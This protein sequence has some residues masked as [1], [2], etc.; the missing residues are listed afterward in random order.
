LPGPIT[1]DATSRAGAVVDYTA[2]AND[3][4]GSGVATSSFLPASG[5]TFPLGMTTVNASATD[6]AGNTAT[7]SFTV[8]VQPRLAAPLSRKTLAVGDPVPDQ[9]GDTG[10]PGGAVVA[11]F[12]VPCV[13]ELGNVSFLMKWTSSEGKGSGLFHNGIAVAVVSGPAATTS[14]KTLGD[15]VGSADHVAFLATLTGVPKANAAAVVSNASSALQVIAQ[16]GDVAPDAD[17][18]PSGAT[19]K[20]FKAVAIAG[21]AVAIFAQL[22]G[23]TGAEKTTAANDYGV[24][25]MDGT[26]SLRLVLR[27][28]QP[29]IGAGTI[30]TLVTFAPGAGSPGQGRGW[31][32]QYGPN[33]G[34]LA[35]ALLTGTDKAQAIL[36][37]GFGGN[38]EVLTQ[39][40][41]A[42]TGPDLTGAT[43]ASFGVPTINA[44][45]KNAFLGSLTI[46]PDIATKADAR[47][48][49]VNYGNPN[50]TTLARVTGPAG[51]TG[52]TF[53]L[54]KDPVLDASADLAF[55]AT[56]KPSTTVKGLAT[57]T[58]W[59]KPVSGAL[60]LL[61][62][63]GAD[64]VGD[65]PDA[66]WKSFTSLAIA[67]GRGPIFAATLVPGQGDVTAKT[68]SGVW[69]CDVTGAV[70]LLFR[71]GVPDAIIAGKTLKKFTLLNASKG[72]T[73]SFNDSGRV[74]WL[75]TFAD[76][77]TAIVTT[78]VP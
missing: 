20:T 60:T 1:F 64:T 41:P 15:P 70:R 16:A 33:P 13:D 32:V 4:G 54:L 50:Y 53:S 65:L 72:V 52:T 44:A 17:G 3:T 61:A 31:L 23:G 73:R 58:L 71:T 7:G 77:T 42:G 48:I 49:F 27:E 11:G 45:A 57:T 8:T 14:F 69:A 6:N 78:E 43:F 9:H 34:V 25:L 51:S 56:L 55:P 67:D 76:K 10:V 12:G 46:A 62:Q 63:G 28:G 5:S 40:G 35:L 68:A 26:H 75:A 29:V 21:D 19:F 38:P 36:A 39:S 66:Q 47:G 2:S 59:W 74:V 37:A 18:L 24:W 22:S 30:K